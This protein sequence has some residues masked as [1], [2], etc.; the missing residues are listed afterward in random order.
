MRVQNITLAGSIGSGKSTVGKILGEALCCEFI[1]TGNI[2]RAIG[3]DSNM[4]TLQTNHAA[5]INTGIDDQIDGF[6]VTR[7]KSTEPFVM[8]SRMA[9]HFVPDSLKVYLYANPYT[10][11]QRVFSDS[12]RDTE[13]YTSIRQAKE[14]I[15]GRRKS[16]IARYRKLYEVDI[17]KIDNYDLFI[18]TDGAEPDEI[19]SI[20]LKTIDEN[21]KKKAWIKT[22]Q[23]V[24]LISTDHM[25]L[26]DK[27]SCEYEASSSLIEV[28]FS[29]GFGYLFDA[30]D[31]SQ[32]RFNKG[33]SFIAFE[34]K[35]PAEVGVENDFF[36][37]ACKLELDHFR[38]WEQL[39]GT[40]LA[41]V[42]AV[43]RY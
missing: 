41:I 5:E 33:N 36:S 9:W 43:Q 21:S 25:S 24:P 23:L 37:L 22:K 6:I 32:F 15:L 34:D 40:S 20:I 4:T 30:P 35:T 27:Q 31:Q 16:E 1:S 10:A 8:D 29:D 19:A 14:D 12:S 2:F 38:K 18:V 11:S 17:D 7:A 26:I 42:E 39:M 28:A 3:K 13:K